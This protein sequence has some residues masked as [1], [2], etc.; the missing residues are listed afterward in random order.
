MK[1]ERTDKI[2]IS[3]GGKLYNARPSN[4]LDHIRFKEA[5]TVKL[6]VE[7]DSSYHPKTINKKDIVSINGV[8]YKG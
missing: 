2:V 6:I 4:G 8:E 1:L 5:G 3:W 7:G